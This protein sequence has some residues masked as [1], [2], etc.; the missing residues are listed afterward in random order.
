MKVEKKII[1]FS[2][3]IYVCFCFC[4]SIHSCFCFFFQKQKQMDNILFVH[5][6]ASDSDKIHN[7]EINPSKF[8][9][10]TNDFSSNIVSK[11]SDLNALVELIKNQIIGKVIPAGSNNNNN[12]NNNNN[13]RENPYF[14]DDPLRVGP[15]RRPMMRNV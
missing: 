2:H 6:K 1:I 12:N 9:T 14:V 10:E 11:F 13:E 8:V 5:I 7:V 4:F 15:P 3:F